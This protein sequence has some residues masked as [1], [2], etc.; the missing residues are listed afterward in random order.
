MRSTETHFPNSSLDKSQI[1]QLPEPIYSMLSLSFNDYELPQ[2]AN[3]S[4]GS[5]RLEQSKNVLKKFKL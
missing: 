4:D 5:L 2:N 3:S 1:Y